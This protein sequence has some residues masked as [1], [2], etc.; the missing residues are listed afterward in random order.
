[1]NKYQIIVWSNFDRTKII[2]GT[3]QHYNIRT[4]PIVAMAIGYYSDTRIE[5][6]ELPTTSH[7]FEAGVDLIIF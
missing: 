2:F 6:S 3:N 5:R 7:S 1:M 4:I